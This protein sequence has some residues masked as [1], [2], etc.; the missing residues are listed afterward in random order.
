MESKQAGLTA[1]NEQE[2]RRAEPAV[3][4]ILL[5]TPPLQKLKGIKVSLAKRAFYRVGSHICGPAAVRFSKVPC[6]IRT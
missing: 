6:M 1:V 5:A 4:C 2:R 3:C